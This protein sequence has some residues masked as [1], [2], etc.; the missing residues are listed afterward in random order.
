MLLENIF[1]FITKFSACSYGLFVRFDQ[2]HLEF[3]YFSNEHRIFAE[4]Y[5]CFQRQILKAVKKRFSTDKTDLPNVSEDEIPECIED[6][7]N[8]FKNY[9]IREFRFCKM[10]D[11]HRTPESLHLLCFCKAYKKVFL[12][13]NSTFRKLVNALPES[14]GFPPELVLITEER[15]AENISCAPFCWDLVC[16]LI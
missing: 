10:K 12:L 9:P 1:Y 3:S 8:I 14:G 7:Q 13:P 5:D 16:N 4:I 2:C 6:L 15:R 11:F